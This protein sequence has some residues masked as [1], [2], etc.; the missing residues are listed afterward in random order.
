LGIALTYLARWPLEHIGHSSLTQ[1][2][3]WLVADL[4]RDRRHGAVLETL[5]PAFNAVKQEITEA[6]AYESARPAS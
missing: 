5:A 4:R 2:R 6:L 1:D 3:V